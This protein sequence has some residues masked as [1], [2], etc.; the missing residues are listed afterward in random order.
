MGGRGE[1]VW[2][3][4]RFAG[5][6][7][8]VRRGPGLP[9]AS[10]RAEGRV[11]GDHPEFGWFIASIYLLCGAFRLA[12]FNCLAAMP[13]GG[14]SKEFLGFPIPSAAGLVASLTLLIIRL[15]ENDKYLGPL[16]VR[17]AGGRAVVS[18]GDDGEQRQVSELQIAGFALHHHFTRK[19]LLP[20]WYS[21]SF[22]CGIPFCIMYCLRFLPPIWFTALSVRAFLIVYATKLK[23]RKTRATAHLPPLKW[24][25]RPYIRL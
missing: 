13:G 4:V 9:G 15:N 3:G 19:S 12:R 7:D 8:L 18:L 5:R 11:R 21:A 23:R 17:P 22:L 1:P 16:E 14:G 25:W 2:A 10:G 24:K 20:P 6:P